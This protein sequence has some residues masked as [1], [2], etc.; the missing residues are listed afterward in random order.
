MSIFDNNFLYANNVADM[1][2]GEEEQQPPADA[3]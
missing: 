2:F 1:A 3:T